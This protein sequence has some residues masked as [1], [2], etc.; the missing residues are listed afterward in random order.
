M[1]ARQG[2]VRAQVRVRHGRRQEARAAAGGSRSRPAGDARGDGKAGRAHVCEAGAR[3]DRAAAPDA[4]HLHGRSQEDAGGGHGV[5]EG[6]GAGHAADAVQSRSDRYAGVHA[7]HLWRR[8]IQPR[9]RAAAG[10]WRVLLDYADSRGLAEGADRLKAARVQ[11]LRAP[12][13]DDPRSDAG[14]LRAVRVRK[15]PAAHVAPAPAQRLRQR[16][17]TSRAGPSTRSS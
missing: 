7:R 5:R 16:R 12:G 10:T 15:R 2:E 3:P 8:R 4:G 14:P 9:A 1:A 6:E 17:R 11:Q 13:V